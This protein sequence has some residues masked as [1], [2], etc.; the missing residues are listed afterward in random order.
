MP[1]HRYPVLVVRDP[2]GGFTAVAVDEQDLAGFGPTA[3]AARDDLKGFLEWAHRKRPH[4]PVPG[5]PRPGVAHVQGDRPPGVPDPTAHLPVRPAGRRPRPV[6]HRHPGQRPTARVAA[7]ARPCGSPTTRRRASRGSPSG[8]PSR[9]SKGSPRRSWPGTWPCR[10]SSWPTSSSGSRGRRRPNRRRAPVHPGPGR[11]AARRA[12]RPQ[13]VRPRLGAGRRGRH[14]RPQAAPGEGQRPRRR[15]AG[16]RQDDA[17]GRG[18]P[19]GREAPGRR[20]QEGRRPAADP[21]AV[22]AD[23]RRADHRRDEVPGP[24]GGA[25]RGR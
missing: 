12:G 17:R 6:R 14:P 23:D 8:T 11:R 20:G 5:L 16:R 10:T 1:T 18:R 24:V 4:M 7:A 3:A 25:G 22:L 13:A 15:R 21:A 2:A 9:S 19:R